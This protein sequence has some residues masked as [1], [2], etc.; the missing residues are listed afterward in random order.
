MLEMTESATRYRICGL[1]LA[2][3][4]SIPELVPASN[5]ALGQVPDIQFRIEAAAAGR[6]PASNVFTALPAGAQG[7][8]CIKEPGGYRLRF[9]GLADFRVD[10]SGREIVCEAPEGIPASTVRHL[11]L[12]QVIPRTLN[13]L[14]I[15][16]LHATAVHTPYGV[17]GFAGLTGVGKS[18]LAASFHLA[19]Y[20]V[21][22]DDCLVL[23]QEGDAIV[24]TPAYPGLR[25]WEDAAAALCVQREDLQPVAH[26]SLKQRVLADSDDEHFSGNR[27]TLARIYNL[28][29]APE[30]E[31]IAPDR[32]VEAIPGQEAFMS[33]MAAAFW[34]DTTD[35]K[36]LSRKFELFERIAALVPIRRL[37][38]SADFSALPAI[39]AAILGDLRVA[40]ATPR[41]ALASELR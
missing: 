5:R 18:T 9:A 15:D 11:L 28:V 30:E 31:A 23:R 33:L 40:G 20:P 16:A 22:S 3:A 14:G 13:L 26:Y 7:L 27:M 38:I 4:I 39:R 1:T 2:S 34:L 17:C 29:D 32:I 41:P 24:A 12:D 37:L 36:E 35:R 25:L 10:T 6:S 21:L 8:V 19:G